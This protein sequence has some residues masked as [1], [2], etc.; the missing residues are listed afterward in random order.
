[1]DRFEQLTVGSKWKHFKGGI[2]EVIAIAT[3]ASHPGVDLVVYKNVSVDRIWARPVEE[4]LEVLGETTNYYRFEE[5]V[6][7]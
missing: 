3:N 4:F 5:I 6:D 7:D 1:M 2:Y